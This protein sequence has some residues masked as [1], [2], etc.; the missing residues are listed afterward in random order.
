MNW[1]TSTILQAI[2]NKHLNKAEKA[3]LDIMMQIADGNSIIVPKAVTGVAKGSEQ[4]SANSSFSAI[5]ND[6]AS[7]IVRL[8][9]DPEYSPTPLAVVV[10]MT[11]KWVLEAIFLASHWK[12]TDVLIDHL[13]LLTP[14]KKGN[15]QVNQQSLALLLMLFNLSSK[16]K[17]PWGQL[18]K[19]SP[20]LVIQGYI[21]LAS[22]KVPALTEKSAAGFSHLLAAA[23]DFPRF[24]I[25]DPKQLVGFSQPMFFAS[26]A[27]SPD[28]YECKKW[29]AAIIRAS[30][31]GFMSK[32]A[33]EYVNNMPILINKPKLK[34]VVVFEYFT[35]NHAMYRCYYHIIKSLSTNY[36][37]VAVVEKNGINNET[38]DL[39]SK[40]IELVD[41][42]DSAKNIDII[43]AEQADIIFYPSIGMQ[44]YG[45][46]LSQL[47][48]APLQIMMGG[49]PSSSF[50]P[51][52]DYLLLPFN[53]GADNNLQAYYQEKIIS[54]E[55]AT[56]GNNAHRL[57]SSVD[58]AFIDAHNHFL[59]DE[60]IIR[61]AINGVMTKVTYSIL[62]ICKKIAQQSEKKIEFIFF[63]SHKKHELGYFAT[64][65]QLQ[66]ELKSFHLVCFTNYPDY[67]LTIS[68]CHLLLPTLP[69]GGSNSNVDAM[70]L[71]KPKLF[72]KGKE[73]IYTRT[74]QIEWERV[75]L[76]DEFGA[77]TGSELVAKALKIIENTD[78]RKALYALMVERCSLNK[79]F[80]ASV[81]EDSAKDLI[82]I[83]GLFN[84]AIEDKLL[85]QK[86]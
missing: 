14:D 67:L 53:L 56:T 15:I 38:V 65:N 50:S 21:G 36:D 22:Q 49:H 17:L 13:K 64:Q 54:L 1:N 46:Y 60:S 86:N 72:L 57:S 51:E 11:R 12:S 2:E 33:T 4:L 73:Q 44:L 34:M 35:I 69:F 8:F 7:L 20:Q 70:I 66:A 39:F 37:L 80:P 24:K 62:A 63:S 52:I 42:N 16:Y 18:F 41:I 77:N 45:V 59:V 47:R 61:I 31:E 27:T 43:V 55:G 26:Y 19:V 5:L 6:L 85:M 76:S 48:L 30:T 10:F 81:K 78:Y 32:T 79:V 25:T 9:S 58:E 75:G 74:D 3:L 28:K 68:K 71:N 82:Q 29:L 23:K 83:L 40:V 84:R